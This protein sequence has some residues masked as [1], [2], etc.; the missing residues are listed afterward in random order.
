VPIA[1]KDLESSLLTMKG[2]QLSYFI[3]QYKQCNLTSYLSWTLKSTLGIKVIEIREGENQMVCAAWC[4]TKCRIIFIVPRSNIP[5]KTK[6]P[7]LLF[8]EDVDGNIFK[9]KIL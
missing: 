8:A 6:P 1:K 3:C 5:E 2:I 9:F 4:F 7:L